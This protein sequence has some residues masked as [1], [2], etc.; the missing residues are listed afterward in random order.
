MIGLLRTERRELDGKLA[1]EVLE[2]RYPGS[3]TG[4]VELSCS[5]DAFKSAIAARKRPGEVAQ[6]KKGTGIVDLALK[7]LA[8]LG[9]V[10]VKVTENVKPHQPKRIK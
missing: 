1:A 5:I 10:A 9:G 8:D 4:A 7:E 6:S 2:R 3:S